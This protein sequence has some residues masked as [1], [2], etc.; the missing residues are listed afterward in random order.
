[1]EDE[2]DDSM[3]EEESETEELDCTFTLE[4]ETTTDELDTLTDELEDLTTEDESGVEELDCTFTLELETTSD[5]LDTP[6]D[7]LEDLTTEEE[8]ICS[9]LEEFSM[10]DELSPSDSE[11]LFPL[12]PSQAAKIRATATIPNSVIRCFCFIC[13]L[14]LALNHRLF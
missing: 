4:L 8:F 10:E 5:E 9:L 11:L 2:L 12:S 1:M 3:V 14:L 13:F 6:I 7:E